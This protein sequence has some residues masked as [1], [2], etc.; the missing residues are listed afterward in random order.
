M[1]SLATKYTP[2]QTRG[3]EANA[4]DPEALRCTMIH[5]PP[6]GDPGMRKYLVDGY[7]RCRLKQ[8]VFLFPSLILV[9]TALR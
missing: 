2:Y 9:L 5:V 8:H 6:G 4:D 1:L 7:G 3:V